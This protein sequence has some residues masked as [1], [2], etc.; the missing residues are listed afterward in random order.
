MGE[1][2]RGRHLLP[3][4]DLLILVLGNMDPF[5]SFVSNSCS[6]SLVES[7]KFKVPKI[8]NINFWIKNDPPP[9]NFS[10]NSTYLVAWPVPLLEANISLVFGPIYITNSWIPFNSIR[11][12]MG[13]FGGTQI[14]TSSSCSSAKKKQAQKLVQVDALEILCNTL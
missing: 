13:K 6:K 2:F 3:L 1:I 10:E 8:C 11:I 7:L 5:G 12:I 4:G 9:W 14:Q